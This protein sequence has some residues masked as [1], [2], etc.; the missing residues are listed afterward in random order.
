MD[1]ADFL[2]ISLNLLAEGLIIT[3]AAPLDG[4][5]PEIIYVN[6]AIETMTGYPAEA[7]IG[8]TPR[9]L[10]CAQTDRAAL[11]RIRAALSAGLPITE[12]LI[13]ARCDGTLYFVEVKIVPERNEAGALIRFISIQRDVSTEMRER[14]AARAHDASFR[15]LF[16]EN[17]TAMYVVDRHSLETLKVNDAWLRLS[18]YNQETALSLRST[19]IRPD[20]QHET[21][22]RD[23]LDEACTGRLAGPYNIKRQ[24]GEQFP[25]MTMRRLI[26]FNG[27]AAIISTLWDVSEI[28][29]ARAQVR[30]TVTQ[31]EHLSTTLAARTIELS[32]AHRLAK[33]GTWMWD[34]EERVLQF[35]PEIWLIMGHPPDDGPVT[36]ERMR[37]MIHPDDYQKTMDQYYRGVKQ[38]TAVTAEYRI[39]LPDGTFRELLTYAEPVIDP[40]R[41]RVIALRGTSQDMTELR[42]IEAQ[43]RASEDHYRHMVDLH[44]Q[45]PWT[46]DPDGRVLDAGAKWFRLTGL[47]ESESFPNGWANVVHSDDL[48]AVM[49]AWGHCIATLMPLDIE[50]RIRSKQGDF[51]WVRVRAAIRRDDHGQPIRW[52]GTMEDITDRRNAENARRES[53]KLAERVINATSDAVIVFHPDLRVRFANAAAQRLFGDEINL[54][55]QSLSRLLRIR[56]N[57]ALIESVLDAYRSNQ[58][59][60]IE[61]FWKHT[62]IWLEI[63]IRPDI[64]EVSLFIRDVSERKRAQRQLQHAASHDPLTGAPNRTVLFDQL[65]T[66]LTTAVALERV[67]LMCLDLDFFKEVNDTF[68]HPAGDTLLKLAV[69]RLRSCIRAKDLL[70]RTGGDEFMLMQTGVRSRRDAELLADRLVTAFKQPFQIEGREVQVG[71]SVGIALSDAGQ[72]TP[73]EIYKQADL[74]LYNAKANNRGR[75]LFFE[76]EMNEE[77]RCSSELRSDLG[78]ALTRGEFSLVFQPIIN[79][80]DQIITGAEALLRWQHPVRGHISPAQFI[81]LAEE[82]GYI[83]DIG[84]WVLMEA[85]RAAKSWPDYVSVSVNVSAKQ[86]DRGDF[87]NIVEHTLAMSG[88]PAERLLLEFTESVFF[89]KIDT[90]TKTIKKLTEL[91]LRIVLDD[92]GTGY[93]SLA[94][95]DSFDFHKVKIDRSFISKV[96]NGRQ[97]MPI[98]EA[99][100]GVARGL[101]LMVT[102]EGIETVAQ[103]DYVKRIGCDE[104]QGVL[105]GRPLSEDTLIQRISEQNHGVIRKI[106]A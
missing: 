96:E 4:A 35:A 75:Y 17:P 83:H 51:L 50:Y 98:L 15:L 16:D 92:F 3:R 44:P 68:G 67:A 36:Y 14:E 78:G 101:G 27:R 85:C 77:F 91:G 39:I 5:G 103:L 73:G 81:P 13:N 100:M 87:I 6:K 59:S 41:D 2:P 74:A 24:N 8:Q 95:L 55:G 60:D 64:D 48:P 54:Q 65:A 104:A 71:V 1:Q 80:R 61:F 62:D 72:Q 47:T 52:Y 63:H 49:A 12:T 26:N 45:I 9:L 30:E 7:L 79:I 58:S 106:R 76:P 18:G 34:L 57:N 56:M 43:L 23:I 22:V 97:A 99:I 38:R 19:D 37:S 28:E 46:A 40:D 53:E 20:V 105:L 84:R 21:L 89:A 88:L 33:V 11:D 86:I 82:A 102:A 69:S 70:A 93:S 94:Y 66:Y 32:H 10:Q 42:L 25:A 31:L 29:A 90:F